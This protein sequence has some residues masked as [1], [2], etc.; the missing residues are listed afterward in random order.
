M[1]NP[2]N[3][4]DWD[5]LAIHEAS[6]DIA[7]GVCPACDDALDPADPKWGLGWVAQRKHLAAYGPANNIVEGYH[8]RCI[9][10]D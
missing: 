3:D 1:F 4:A 10:G 9:E 2:E 8:D 5:T 6:R 7:N